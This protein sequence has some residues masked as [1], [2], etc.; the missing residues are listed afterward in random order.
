MMDERGGSIVVIGAGITGLTVAYELSKRT[1]EKVIVVEKNSYV[2]GLSATLRGGG[3]KYDLG[4]HRL[5]KN[6]QPR[7]FEYIESVLGEKLLKRPRGGRFYFNGRYIDYPPNIYTII[8]DFHYSGIVK[9]GL[10][11]LRGHLSISKNGDDNFEKIMRR[12]VGDEAYNSFYRDYARKLWGKEPDE[13]SLDVGRRSRFLGG[14][15]LFTKVLFRKNDFYYYPREGIGSI[16][17]R[18]RD[19][20]VEG[21]GEI[22]L[23][24]RVSEVKV[25]DKRV[26]YVKVVDDEGVERT[27]ES[28]IVIS[29]MPIDELYNMMSDVDEEEKL[30]WRGVRIVY[31]LMKDEIKHESETFYFPQSSVVFGRV[32][33]LRKYSPYVNPEMNETLLTVEIPSN[34]GD[35]IWEMSEEDA[36]K[37]CVEELVKV[38]ILDKHPN[39]VKSFSV[40]MEDAY[41]I[42]VIGWRDKFQRIYDSVSRIKNLFTL[43]RCGLFLHCNIDHCVIQALEL[44]DFI[45]NHLDEGKDYWW[46]KSYRFLKFYARE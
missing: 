8:R 15:E 13:M 12:R 40:R 42:F 2:G 6:I 7:V 36:L 24:R 26:E 44:T 31:I 21:G 32:S 17:E 43:G 45:L 33:E 41:P 28:S 14:L 29:T 11:Y 27:I 39:I 46:K 1:D 20:I 18:L 34:R 22:L 16:C 25:N 30:E 4:S 35:D 37:V 19:R 5:H 23:N 3:V 9:Y 38:K 10:S